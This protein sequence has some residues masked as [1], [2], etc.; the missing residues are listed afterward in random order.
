MKR[1]FCP[2]CCSRYQ[3]YKT[4]SDGVLICGQCGDPMIKKPVINPRQFF[5]WVALSAFLA[6][7]FIMIA[8]VI[9]DISKER[10]LN[11]SDSSAFL[12]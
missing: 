5:G 10:I 11:N 3:L 4:R 9:N 8:L 1:Y 12:I 2:F 6:P 7:L